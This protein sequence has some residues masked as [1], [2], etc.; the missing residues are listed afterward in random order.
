VGNGDGQRDAVFTVQADPLRTRVH[1]LKRFVT[2]KGG[3]YFFLPSIR[4][5]R[6]LSSL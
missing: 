3:D 2:V 1:N 5:L 6:F 4:A